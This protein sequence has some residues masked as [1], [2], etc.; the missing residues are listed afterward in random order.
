[1]K[2]LVEDT[3]KALGF[4]SYHWTDCGGVITTHGGPNAFGIAGYSAK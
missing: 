4:K 1:M 3:V 2:A